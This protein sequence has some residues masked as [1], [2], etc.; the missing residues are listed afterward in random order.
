VVTLNATDA[1]GSAGLVTKY[2]VVTAD[3]T[4]GAERTYDATAK[5]ELGDGEKLRY[6]TTDGAGNAETAH[7]SPAAKVDLQAPVTGDDVPSTY[8]NAPVVVTLSVTDAGGSADLV[9]KYRIVA[10]DGTAGAEQ[11]YDSGAKPELGDGEKLRYFTT[12]GAGNAETAHDSPAAKVD[13]QTP[14]TADDVPSTY[15]KAPIVVT[16]SATDSGGSADLV[17][18]YRLRSPSPSSGLLAAS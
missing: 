6:F 15:R 10:G 9:T 11:V 16:L 13:Q 17:T 2:R 3:G 12:D 18:K 14:V 4:V 5:P 8:R 7:D 1:G